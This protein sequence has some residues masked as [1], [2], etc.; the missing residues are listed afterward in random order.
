MKIYNFIVYVSFLAVFLPQDLFSQI[1]IEEIARIEASNECLNQSE[2]Y[3]KLVSKTGS[4]NVENGHLVQKDKNAVNARIF[5]NDSQWV[6]CKVTARIKI[7]SCANVPESGFS[8]IVRAN[9]SSDTFIAVRL[10]VSSNRVTIEKSNDL[11]FNKLKK[12]YIG[13][14][15]SV[16]YKFEKNRDYK[17]TVIVDRATIYCIIDDKFVVL[18][19]NR[20]FAVF[21]WVRWAFYL[22]MPQEQ[23]PMFQ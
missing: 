3:K 17:V 8:I 6:D 9:D 23:L 12:D 2:I 5:I 10:L 18:D 20:F 21:L 11:N 13:G 1:N 22:I 19:R 7:T 14:I 4:W 16:D 15:A